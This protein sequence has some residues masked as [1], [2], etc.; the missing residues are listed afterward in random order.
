MRKPKRPPNTYPVSTMS[1][2]MGLKPP[3]PGS[4]TSRNRSV[5]LTATSTPKRAMTFVLTAWFCTSSSS[6]ARQ[7]T[8]RSVSISA[9][10]P[11]CA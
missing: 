8:T 9:L 11:A 3:G 10:S 4:A 5:A 7:M 2:K 6:S 1:G